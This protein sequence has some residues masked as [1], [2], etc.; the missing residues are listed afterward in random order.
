MRLA[1]IQVGNLALQRL[2]VACGR[3]RAVEL[4]PEPVAGVKDS[5]AYEFVIRFMI[6]NVKPLIPA[7]PFPVANA[8]YRSSLTLTRQRQSLTTTTSGPIA[9]T[10]AVEIDLAD[11]MPTPAVRGWKANL[12]YFCLEPRDRGLELEKAETGRKQRRTNEGAGA[13]RLYSKNVSSFDRR[14][15]QMG[16]P[17]T[18]RV[19]PR[20]FS[21]RVPPDLNARMNRFAS[22][23]LLLALVCSS[24]RAQ[25]TSC[26]VL[27]TTFNQVRTSC[28]TPPLPVVRALDETSALTSTLATPRIS[29]AHPVLLRRL[30]G[31][32]QP[33]RRKPS[34]RLRGAFADKQHGLPV[35]SLQRVHCGSR[36]IPRSLATG[37][38]WP[39][40]ADD[41]HVPPVT[42]MSR[43]I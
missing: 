15:A 13:S 8:F 6:P 21:D 26:G 33:D 16:G 12:C 24:V 30:S 5:G 31:P 41:G 14:P 37:A 4:G 29:S 43:S 34:G 22:L 36:G 23:L 17:S 3:H 9:E 32:K 40:I 39:K 20:S 27:Q 38:T 35:L 19:I 28:A 25:S 11:E 2:L 10:Q 7:G 18:R 42:G 1:R